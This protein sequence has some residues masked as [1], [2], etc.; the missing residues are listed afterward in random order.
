MEDCGTQVELMTEPKLL[1]TT[2]TQEKTAQEKFAFSL[3][4]KGV[5]IIT[6]RSPIFL[7]PTC[8]GQGHDVNRPQQ[9]G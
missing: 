8:Q 5:D 1:T 3:K 6:E 7:R 2:L 9:C 4:D